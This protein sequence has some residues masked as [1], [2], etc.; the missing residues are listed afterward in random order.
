MRGLAPTV[1]A[2]ALLAS[3]TFGLGATAPA[4]QEADQECEEVSQETEAFYQEAATDKQPDARLSHGHV[5]HSP[6]PYQGREIYYV[7]F[8]VNG[9]EEIATWAQ[10]GPDATQAMQV[11][12]RASYAD[13]LS[14]LGTAGSPDVARISWPGA[15]ESQECVREALDA[16]G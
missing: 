5:V 14:I 12:V 9:G 7:S 2:V 11:A 16:S 1:A 3:T 4:N 15:K 6:K 8:A 10:T 13:E